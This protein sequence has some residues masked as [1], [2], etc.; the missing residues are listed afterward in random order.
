MASVYPKKIK[1]KK[2][3]E[4]T[5]RWYVGYYQ[6][7]KHRSK[8]AGLSKTMAQKLRR[9]IEA[10]L[11]SGKFDFLNQPDTIR[12]EDSISGYLEH[13]QTLR[14][15]KTF[16][17]YRNALD[18]LLRF[19]REKHKSTPV[20]R[21]LTMAQFSDY[22]DW[23]RQQEIT[24]NGRENSPTKKVPTFKTINVEL[25][26]FRSWIN[27][28]VEQ[29]HTGKNPL[30]GLKKLKTTDS[31]PRRVLTHR[32]YEKLLA[33]SAKMEMLHPVRQGQTLV[34]QFLANTGLRIGELVNLQWNDIDFRRQVIKIQRKPGW[35]PKTY[36]REVPFTREAGTILRELREDRRDRT[37]LIFRS[38]S[39][40]PLRENLVRIW[41]LE[42]AKEAGL[43]EMRGPHDLRHTFITWALTEYGIDVPTVQKIV[44][45]K[46][47][48]TTQAYLHPTTDHI[49]SAARKFGQL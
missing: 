23:R 43:N 6:D 40:K 29:G 41:L 19:L 20:V 10:E 22:Q 17:R 47:L 39:G 24:P 27:W 49:R 25:S 32:E 8:S 16:S 28:A 5:I 4:V 2:T 45:H 3:G 46:N 13:V 48:E 30:S 7:G 33:V 36:E 35:D 18:H 44:G 26:I 34:W 14:K 11:Q 21:K 9:Q 42:C 31:K 15:P 37:S 1:S 12:I 38:R